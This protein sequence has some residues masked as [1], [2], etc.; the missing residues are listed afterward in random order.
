M[1][2]KSTEEI[3][4]DSE[5]ICKLSYVIQSSLAHFDN[6]KPMKSEVIAGAIYDFICT[7]DE[8]LPGFKKMFFELSETANRVEREGLQ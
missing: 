2:Q 6:F 7:L 5:E 8:G 3:E 1:K 4:M